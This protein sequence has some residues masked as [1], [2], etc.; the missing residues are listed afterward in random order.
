MKNQI[1]FASIILSISLITSSAMV[2][3]QTQKSASKV[4]K[5]IQ[6]MV[7][8]LEDGIDVSNLIR[9]SIYT[10]EHSIRIID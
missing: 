5:Q 10:Q 8:S 6:K 1:I 9:G 3:T 2:C 7:N 4:E